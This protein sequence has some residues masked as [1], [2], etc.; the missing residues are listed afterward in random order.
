M[1]IAEMRRLIERVSVLRK[2]A[3]E[4]DRLK[5]DKF[6]IFSILKRETLETSTHSAFIAELLNP[7][8]SHLKGSVFLDLFLDVI[9]YKEIDTQSA[10]VNV[11]KSI[12][13]VDQDRATGG[14]LDI[15]IR[16][17]YGRTLVIENKINAPDQLNQIKRYHAYNPTK[18]KVYYLTLTG[19]PP[20]KDSYGDLD[21]E[22]DFICISY[23]DVIIKWLERCLRASVEEPIL[24]ET[25]KQYIILIKKLTGLINQE[26][27][28]ELNDLLID[29]YASAKMISE[30]LQP[31]IVKLRNNFRNDIMDRLQGVVKSDFILE[32]GA[33][34]DREYSGIWI[35][36]AKSPLRLGIES[37]SGKGHFD[38]DLFCGMWLWPESPQYIPK[39]IESEATCKGWPVVRMFPEYQGLK[40]NLDSP[41]FL[42]KLNNDLPFREGVIK[43]IVDVFKEFFE[44]HK[45][46]LLAAKI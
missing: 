16:D 32:S 10:V 23:R 6:N 28:K 12:G 39:D 9:N 25:I 30:N 35:K 43:Y 1:E 4:I 18:S 31:A 24:R 27:E 38:G 45:E 21:P 8:G 5:G 41:E 14:K 2:H 20:E 3:D 34:V 36:T 37:F 13:K 44:T 19:A 29:N 11:E 26:M 40:I 42:K 46:Y 33:N 22:K 15:E 7:Q 17:K